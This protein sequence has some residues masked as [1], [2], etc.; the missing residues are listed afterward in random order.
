MSLAGFLNLLKPP[1]MTSHDVVSRVRRA[2]GRKVKVGHLGT[3]DPA[4]A[5]VLPVAVG[6]ATKLIPLVPDLGPSMKSYLG[7]L[8]LGVTTSTD[9]LEGEVLSRSDF[10]GIAEEHL[11]EALSPFVG[12]VQ[13]V[14]PQV[15]AVR[16]DGV[17]AYE[18]ARKGQEVKLAARTVHIERAELLDYC[19]AR[20]RLKL[21]L[22]CGSG[23]YVRS[24]ARDLGEALGVGASLAYLLRT[25]SG[26]FHLRDSY[27]LEELAAGGPESCLLP[28]SYP[29]SHLLKV[30]VTE[31]I[32]QKGQLLRGEFPDQAKFWCREALLRPG[33]ESGTAVVD[34]LFYP[35]GARTS[36]RESETEPKVWA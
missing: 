19:A 17:R 6:Q 14:P 13:Q 11:R 22:V 29:F 15:S 1:G 28:C 18:R 25:H 12:A 26:P 2:V 10:N 16:L 20:G 24:L 27:T 4:A 35:L 32:S 34:A 8:Q 23:T 7:H 3:L 5:G 33:S 21:F 30:E 9:D 36:E 31:P